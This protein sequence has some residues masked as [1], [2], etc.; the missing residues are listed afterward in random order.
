[1]QPRSFFVI[2]SQA[3]RYFSFD[4]R[5]FLFK[6]P[7]RLQG[8]LGG[9]GAN[10]GDILAPLATGIPKLQNYIFEIWWG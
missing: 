5:T 6:L 8:G 7:T 1:M 10:F 9:W 4:G 3:K 2:L